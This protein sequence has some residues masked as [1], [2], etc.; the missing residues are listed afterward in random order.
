MAGRGL[1][2]SGSGQ[3]MIGPLWASHS[4]KIW[5]YSLLNEIILASIR[6]FR[7]LQLHGKE[8]RNNVI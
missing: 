4:K 6:E 3:G 7:F 2:L 8:R 1:N 5:R